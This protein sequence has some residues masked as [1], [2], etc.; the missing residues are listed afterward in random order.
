MKLIKSILLVACIVATAMAAP[1]NYNAQGVLN[2]GHFSQ[3][4][5]DIRQSS[6]NIVKTPARFL[7]TALLSVIISSK[8]L[9]ADTI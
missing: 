5:K 8:T 9:Q 7:I 1:D 3:G 6:V 2:T 4:G